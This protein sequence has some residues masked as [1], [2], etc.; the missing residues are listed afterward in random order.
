[1]HSNNEDKVLMFLYGL[2]LVMAVIG[3]GLLVAMLVDVFNG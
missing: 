3:A 2:C 1:M